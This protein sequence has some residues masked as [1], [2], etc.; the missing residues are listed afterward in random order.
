MRRSQGQQLLNRSNIQRIA[1]RAPWPPNAPP[2][3]LRWGRHRSFTHRTPWRAG[4]CFLLLQGQLGCSTRRTIGGQAT[5]KEEMSLRQP[6]WMLDRSQCLAG[7]WEGCRHEERSA[8]CWSSSKAVALATGGPTDAEAG[9]PY[10]GKVRS[11]S[12]S[13]GAS[14]GRVPNAKPCFVPSRLSQK[15]SAIATLPLRISVAA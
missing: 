1:P 15:L 14:L 4:I 11:M 2:G 3:C 6:V 9:Q 8:G 10:S 5:P 7:H 13:I 12:A